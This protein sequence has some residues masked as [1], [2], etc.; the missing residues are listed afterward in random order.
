VGRRREERDGERQKGD[1]QRDRELTPETEGER[2]RD[3][4]EIGKR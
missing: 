2:N 1:R 3:K 4:G